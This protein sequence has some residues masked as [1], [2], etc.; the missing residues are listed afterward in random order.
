MSMRKDEMAHVSVAVRTRVDTG[1]DITLAEYKTLWLNSYERKY[2][3]TALDDE[4]LDYVVRHCLANCGRHNPATYDGVLQ[5][6][7]VPELLRRLDIAKIREPR[8]QNAHT[9]V[10]KS[11]PA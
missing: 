7:L 10:S 5:D 11:N 9:E 6:G 3:L 4:A 8:E 1:E 2:I